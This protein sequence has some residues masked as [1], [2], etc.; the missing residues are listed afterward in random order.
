MRLLPPICCIG[1]VACRSP[2]PPAPTEP[3][4]REPD[5]YAPHAVLRH[6]HQPS[7]RRVTPVPE[8]PV[9]SV[10]F[11]T[12]LRGFRSDTEFAV[13][14]PADTFRILVVGDSHIDGVV[15][16]AESFAAVLPGL[17]QHVHPT[18][19]VI[20]GGTGYW[21]PTEY[22][23]AFDV[24]ADLTPDL[25]VVVIYEGNDFLDAMATEERTGQ[26]ALKR[27]PGHF[28]ELEAVYPLAGE[29]VSQQLNQDLLFGHDP[30]AA[31]DAVQ[32]TADALVAARDT[33]Q[34][35]S[36]PLMV[37]RL[38]PVG[39]VHPPSREEALQLSRALTRPLWMS[40][41]TLGDALEAELQTRA[42]TVAVLDLWQPLFRAARGLTVDSALPSVW[43]NP[44]QKTTPEAMFWTTDRH[45]SVGG[46]RVLAEALARHLGASPPPQP[47]PSH[48]E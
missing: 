6:V 35:W 38:P 1:L 34:Q 39:A 32:R 12:N 11:R 10:T 21:G 22:G 5:Y 44:G 27:H 48:S 28:T 15:D 16:N 29:R 43:D 8:H 9:G 37:L 31:Q 47:V 40:G 14:K 17:L 18:V 24:W 46:H 45:L 19:E 42:P 26:R 25:C 13:P 3:W 23:Q 4:E 2:A 30:T 41:R 33:C 36:A 20:N 7:A